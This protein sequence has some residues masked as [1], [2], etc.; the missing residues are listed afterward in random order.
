MVPATI[1]RKAMNREAIFSGLF[2]IGVGV[3]LMIWFGRHGLFFGPMLMLFGVLVT[4]S[5]IYRP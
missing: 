1:P 5:G 4:L 2:L 3:V